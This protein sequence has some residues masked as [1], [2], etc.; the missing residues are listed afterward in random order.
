MR[1]LADE[2]LNG[3]IIRSLL[4][5]RPTLDLVRVQDVGL[6]TV[7]DAAILEW[8]AAQGRILLTHDRAT[9]PDFAFQRVV[10]RQSMPGVFVVDERISLR[11]VIDEL[12]LVEDCS[13]PE[14]W[15]GKVIYLPL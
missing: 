14:E 12:L 8:A 4:Y 1:W 3:A 6:R 9:I 11:Q 13:A 15:Q 5:R 2:N 10:T 7:D